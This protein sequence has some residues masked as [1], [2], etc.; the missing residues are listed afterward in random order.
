MNK[1]D[2]YFLDRVEDTSRRNHLT[3]RINSR[4]RFMIEKISLVQLIGFES[5]VL[6]IAK[7]WCSI[8]DPQS[9]GTLELEIKASEHI[10]DM[11]AL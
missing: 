3:R 4:I 9:A 7:T 5:I 11:L 8:L 2:M 6:L 1:Y 10:Q